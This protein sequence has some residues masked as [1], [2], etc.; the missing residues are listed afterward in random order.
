MFSTKRHQYFQQ[1]NLTYTTLYFFRGKSLCNKLQARFQ[2]KIP[3]ISTKIDDN[4]N[5]NNS[6]CDKK[7]LI[8]IGYRP[9]L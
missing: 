6:Q 4:F 5:I 1:K 9:A 8:E 3:T 2:Q 7:S